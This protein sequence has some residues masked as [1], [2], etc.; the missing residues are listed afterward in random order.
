MKLYVKKT[1]R[2]P[3]RYEAR[4]DTPDGEKDRTSFPGSRFP[5]RASDRQ[6]PGKVLR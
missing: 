2:W 3:G 1:K 6:R 4:L 5:S